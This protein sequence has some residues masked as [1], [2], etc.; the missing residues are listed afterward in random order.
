MATPPPQSP[1][2]RVLAGI[3]SVQDRGGALH[4][5]GLSGSGASLTVAVALHTRREDSRG[6]VLWLAPDADEADR[7]TRELRF[8]GIPAR[9]MPSW[10]VHPYGGYSP[11]MDV[12]RRRL[13]ALFALASEPAPVVVASP[14]ALLKMGLPPAALRAL[15]EELVVGEEIDRDGL[16]SRLV[17]RGYLSTDLCSEPGT[18]SVRGGI[19][20]VFAPT[21]ELP[22]RIDFWGDE[23]ESIRTFDPHTSRSRTPMKQAVLLPIREEVVTEAALEALPTRLK[24]LADA[25]GVIPRK[26]IQ[27]QDEL[28]ESRLVQEIELYLPL[29]RS[30][31]LVPVLDYL[32]RPHALLVLQQ[33]EAITNALL[34]ETEQIHHRY[35]REDGPGRLLPEPEALWLDADQLQA[36]TSLLPR[37]VLPD[38]AEAELEP[39]AQLL[40]LPSPDHSGLR[41]ELLA[42]R[43]AED[44]MLEP[45]AG[46]VRGWLRDGHVAM[47][48]CRSRRRARQLAELLRPYGVPVQEHEQPPPLD[49][50]IDRDSPL[51]GGTHLHVVL[52]EIER[53]L[54]LPSLGLFLVSEVE[55]FGRKATSRRRAQRPQGAEAIGSFAQLSPGDVVVHS[56]HGIGRFVGM[57]KIQLDPS[58]LDIKQAQRERAADPSYMPGS[59]GKAGADRGSHNDYLL[60]HYRGGDRLYLPVHKLDQLSRYVAPG[61]GEPTL[62]K[63]GGSTWAKRRKK[64]SEAA[65]KV[66]AE[67]L[68]LYAKRQTAR[69]H[70]FPPPDVLYQEFVE[71]FPYEETPD[72]QAAIDAVLEDMSGKKPMDRLVCGDVG[73]GKTEVAMRAAF[74]AIEDGK[75]VAMLVP[76]T[77]LALQ[78]THAFVER[79]ERFPVRIEMLSR[80]RTAAEQKAVLRDLASGRVDVVIGTHR[81]TSRD[82]KFADLGLVIVDEEHRFGVKH[83][84]RLKELRAAVDVL[85]LTATPIPRTLNLAFAGIRDFSIIAT[86][87]EGRQPVRTQVVR[88]S[89][90]RIQDAILDELGRGGQVY[91]VHNRVKSIHKMADWLRKLVPD[92]SIRIAHG[93]MA[94][95][96]LEDIMVGFFRREF[97]VL[98]CTTIIESG[99]DLPSANTMIINRA[100]LLGLAQM[101]QLRGRV[102]RGNVQGHCHLVVPPGRTVRSEALARLKVLQ[103]HSDLGSGHRIAQHDMELRGTGNMLGK[104]QAGHVADVGLATYMEL[105]ENAVRKL[106]GEK[107]EV[108]LDPEIE[109]RADAYIP[110]E[111]I[112][113]EGERL[114]EY[115]LLADARTREG[116]QA[117]LVE[118]EDT[119]GPAPPEVRRFEQLIEVKVL[120]RELRVGRLRTVR[121]GRLQ[122]T[123][124]A[125]TPLDPVALMGV[126]AGNPQ[127]Y[128]F[129]QDGVL[130]YS[131]DEAERE[132]LVAAALGLLGRLRARCVESAPA[133]AG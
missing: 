64:A 29:L 75:Q 36:A 129:R 85:T 33:P 80:F 16:V 34:A 28:R 100:D 38:V 9:R 116:L 37:L 105:L 121:G 32:D 44:G 10:D 63:L 89:P 112:P 68:E 45:F 1:S 12:S 71:G 82:V 52:G 73:F 131:L 14:Q 50:L 48:V 125:G 8:F 72:Q 99:I 23:I 57:T 126:V 94:E 42:R 118:L 92:V 15:A 67:L 30:E 62:D 4:V 132:D 81:L 113:D 51:R 22:L 6:P 60:L 97:D 70:A 93:Q 122:V 123:I 13:A 106:R 66:A 39:D 20:D 2:G 127:R 54:S 53:G 61:G 27:I 95:Q 119:F 103:D 25:R 102:G 90:R 5:A 18:Y 40:R 133:Q 35:A 24:A 98:L 69:S 96:Q 114:L 86:P 108:G 128:S 111:Y 17:D 49:D 55:I 115:K 84:E 109:L 88:F 41:A 65:Q 43:S 104:R 101:H 107:V 77:I 31:P 47:V 19:L 83:K 74:R 110:S 76:T 56:L 21:Y 7:V 59:G 26:R 130:H 3:A 79:M 58:A 117:A 124:E 87:P 11:S 78:H 120:A 46:K 91:F